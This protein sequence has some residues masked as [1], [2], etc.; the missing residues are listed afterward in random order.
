MV[1]SSDCTF[2]RTFGTANRSAGNVCIPLFTFY[3]CAMCQ[4]KIASASSS[5]CKFCSTKSTFECAFRLAKAY[6]AVGALGWNLLWNIII[7]FFLSYLQ[8]TNLVWNV[9]KLIV[10]VKVQEMSHS[11]AGAGKNKW[12]SK[13]NCWSFQR[14]WYCSTWLLRSKLHLQAWRKVKNNWGPLFIEAHLR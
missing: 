4:V 2:E 11:N 5:H 13:K 3:I 10:S 1:Q 6:I 8:L 7:F 12:Y 9:H 14:F